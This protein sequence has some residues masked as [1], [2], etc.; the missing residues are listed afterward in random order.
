MRIFGKKN[1]FV[2]HLNFNISIVR[3]FHKIKKN[4]KLP[5]NSR[6]LSTDDITVVTHVD[7][8]CTHVVTYYTLLRIFPTYTNVCNIPTYTSHDH[9]ECQI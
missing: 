5:E 6:L 2:C 3:I 9:I 4:K 7:T 8:L 1:V